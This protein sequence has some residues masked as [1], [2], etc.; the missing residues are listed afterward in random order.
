MGVAGVTFEAIRTTV[1]DGETWYLLEDVCRWLKARPELAREWLKHYPGTARRMILWINRYD[2]IR[3][4]WCTGGGVVLVAAEYG[5]IANYKVRALVGAADFPYGGGQ[6]GA[7]RRQ[8][9]EEH[10]GGEA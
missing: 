5:K 4:T 7:E 1:E 9:V 10:G 8:G 6:S 2:A 3:P